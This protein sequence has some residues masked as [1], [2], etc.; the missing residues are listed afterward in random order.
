MWLEAR[1]ELSDG[2]VLRT[3]CDGPPGMWGSPPISE[4]AHL[5]KVRDCL[6]RRL[7]ADRAEAVIALARDME[8]LDTADV[9]ELLRLVA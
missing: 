5:A 7:P 2:R 9:R 4:A 6:S 1:V 3:R 8:Q